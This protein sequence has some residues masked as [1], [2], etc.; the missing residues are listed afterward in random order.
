MVED[1]I[2]FLGVFEQVSSLDTLTLWK[3]CLPA[4]QDRYGPAHTISAFTFS[5]FNARE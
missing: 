3:L 5:C 4:V 1:D 2:A